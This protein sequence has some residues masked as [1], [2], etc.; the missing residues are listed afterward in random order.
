MQG[1][2]TIV[3]ENQHMGPVFNLPLFMVA[4]L[5]LLIALIICIRIT[6]RNRL[7]IHHK[8]KPR[9]KVYT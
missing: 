2:L 8:K 1:T 9:E 7:Y 6:R 5:I 3:N 4:I